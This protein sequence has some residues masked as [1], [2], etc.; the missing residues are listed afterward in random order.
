MFS[1]ITAHTKIFH[2]LK[3]PFLVFFVFQF[4][5]I[6]IFV[7][8]IQDI[9]KI[10]NQ[11]KQN[12][13]TIESQTITNTIKQHLA[14]Y[15]TILIS[16]RGFLNSSDFVDRNEWRDYYHSLEI[17]ANFPAI[18]SLA[19]I[20][21]VNNENIKSYE[22]S[23]RLD[24]SLSDKGYP[25]FTTKLL[26][27][28]KDHYIVHYLEPFNENS[29]VFGYDYSAEES[30]SLAVEKA[31]DT[32]GLV[33]TEPIHLLT[34]HPNEKSF[35]MMLPIYK[36][37][38]DLKSL[39]LRREN[40]IGVIQVIVR[41]KDFFKEVVTT[42][43]LQD[44]KAMQVVDNLNNEELLSF[45]DKKGVLDNQQDYLAIYPVHKSLV[46]IGSR[47][48][49]ITFFS[50]LNQVFPLSGKI[51]S[52]IVL[53]LGNLISFLL[54]LIIFN[55]QRLRD[56]AEELAKNLNKDL[57]KFLLAV[58]NAS[59]QIVITDTE[60]I[61]LY[62]NPQTKI[63]TGF[64]VSEIIGNEIG[65]LWGGQMENSF[66]QNMWDIIKNKKQNYSGQLVNKRKNGTIYEAEIKIA[67]VFDDRGK[68]LFF[69]GIERDI[70]QEKDLA[71]M[72][73][74]FVSVASHELRTPLTAID[75]LISMIID[76][77]YGKVAKNI[78][79]PLKDV[80]SSSKRLINLVNDMLNVSRIEAGKL[81]YNF[82]KF[83]L[84]E[85]I[86][87]QAKLL[88]IVAQEKNLSL[89]FI[90][91]TDLV[92]EADR[93]KVSQ[94]LNNLLGNALKFTT[95][96]KITITTKK[97]DTHAFVY[98]AD[99]GV[100]IKDSDKDKLFEKFKQFDTGKMRQAGTGLGLYISKQI[101]QNMRGDLKLVESKLGKGSVFAFSLPLTK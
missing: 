15:E 50:D 98:V 25:E 52:L 54:A 65:E 61:I 81:E 19:L 47:N 9:A 21:L 91:L 18:S 14:N 97:D 86:Q 93:D 92:V 11:R 42:T 59:D 78:Q 10:E 90:A 29:P 26:S 45:I 58:E 71:R 30:R 76:G 36:T 94:I 85:L 60:G 43:Q 53:A 13:F 89:E 12:D 40:F 38:A 32:N 56:R 83:N 75:G 5:S 73:D 101:C 64:E 7:L 44:I 80:K 95:K 41:A 72:K 57:Q 67:P 74:E 22:R 34:D 68:I 82:S 48:W 24:K 20:K 1:L 70:T 8:V 55:M 16:A 66:Y 3:L 23:V 63:N 88:N 84:K 99:T 69:V 96:G 6:A 17:E 37:D 2:Q 46:S 77:D 27:D 87:E 31:R 100:G 4:I 62:A 49:S 35:L 39:E 28:K 33:V 79:E 51:I